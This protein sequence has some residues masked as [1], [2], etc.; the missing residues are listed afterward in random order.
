[1]KAP[2]AA[3]HFTKDAAQLYD[4]RNRRL[5]PMWDCMHF[6]IRLALKDSPVNSRALC[7]GV[8]TGAEVL[9][10]AEAFPEWT[11]VALD[12]SAAMLEVCKQRLL[13]AGILDRCQLVHGYVE[14]VPSGEPF[15]VA[16]SVLVA[17]F[18]KREARLDF[19]RNMTRR[20]KIGGHL[21]STEIS[22][23]LAS[24]EFPEMMKNWAAVQ[25]CLGATPESLANLPR[26][27]REMLALVSP[28]ETEALFRASG[29]PAP[30]RFFQAFMVHGWVGKREAR[31]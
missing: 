22:F 18:V 17:H 24:P 7:V 13:E 10:L 15:D 6:L 27:L 29:I 20:L 28:E 31:L 16:L 30:I 5:A 14:D 8:G 9:K 11:F 3:D 1:M 26:V 19:I 4:E 12:P 25:T 2:S 21:V 23:D